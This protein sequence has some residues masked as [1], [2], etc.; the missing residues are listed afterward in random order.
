MA[1]LSVLGAVARDVRIVDAEVVWGGGGGRLLSAMSS[2]SLSRSNWPRF[3]LMEVM[4]RWRIVLESALCSS[5]AW[6]SF[7]LCEALELVDGGV[8]VVLRGI[9]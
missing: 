3:L 4:R 6:C 1:C 7:L 9:D 5:S 8:V 2:C